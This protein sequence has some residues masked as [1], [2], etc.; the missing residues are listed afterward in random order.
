MDSAALVRWKSDIAIH[1]QRA[2][3]SKSAFQGTLFDLAPAYSDPDLIDP[4]SLTLQSMAF[5]RFPTDSP[6]DACIYFIIDNAVPLILYIGETCRSNLRWKGEHD[7]KRYLDNYQSLHHRH[8]L[9]SAVNMAFW[10][11]APR[12]TRARQHME[13]SLIA[14]WKSPFNKQNWTFWGAPFVG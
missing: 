14:K 7:C 10:W 4:F 9:K 6:G 2:R 13:S 11:D 1:Q 5:W 8:G 12:Q 3:E